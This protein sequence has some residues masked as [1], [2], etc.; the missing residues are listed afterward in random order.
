[1]NIV[2]IAL[3]SYNFMFRS[4]TFPEREKADLL[5][6]PTNLADYSNRELEKAE[7][8]FMHGY[9]TTQETIARLLEENRSLWKTEEK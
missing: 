8:I 7:E 5:I 1:M 3:R 4:N 6:E 2:S 9:E